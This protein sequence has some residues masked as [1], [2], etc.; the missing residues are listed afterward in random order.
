MMKI[1]EMK[2]MLEEQDDDDFVQI[3]A[4]NAPPYVN[5]F[6]LS[7]VKSEDVSGDEE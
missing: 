1:S 2:K 3:S 4:P 6:T 5:A 7:I